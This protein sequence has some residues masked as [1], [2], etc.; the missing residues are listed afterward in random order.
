MKIII[1]MQIILENVI[2][3]ALSQ[4][5]G[6][7]TMIYL[8]PIVLLCVWLQIKALR[9]ITKPLVD[10]MFGEDA[11]KLNLWESIISLL[12]FLLLALIMKFSYII[13]N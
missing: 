2:A 12:S 1:K 9:K 6:S 8:I 7:E 10:W 4:N 3:R 11:L 5:E 13:I